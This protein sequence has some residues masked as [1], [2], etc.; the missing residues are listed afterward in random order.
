M[1]D[2]NNSENKVRLLKYLF[3]DEAQKGL[4]IGIVSGLLLVLFIQPILE[5]ITNLILWAG[6]HCYAGFSTHIYR[7]ASLGFH[8]E[9]S[10]TLLYLWFAII[11]G[12]AVLIT[13]TIFII[14]KRL[15]TNKNEY[16]TREDIPKY[17]YMRSLLVSLFFLLI[18]NF[19]NIACDFARFQLNTSFNHRL[20]ILAAKI[21]DQEVK[22]LKAE[23]ASMQNQKDYRAI[24]CKMDYLAQK[25]K[26]AL[27]DLLWM[28]E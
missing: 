24:V 15:S 14:C 27:P 28:W 7:S 22:T 17:P 16:E 23:W 8:E 26:I 5:M 2:E 13:W 21:T 19:F 11:S 20:T 6:S 12:S 10:Y 9:F 25:N 3:S 4:L 1:A 18:L